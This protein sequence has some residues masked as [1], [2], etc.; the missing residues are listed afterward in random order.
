MSTK[1]SKLPASAKR[2]NPFVPY[3]R[4]RL[5][6]DAEEVS[7]RPCEPAELFEGLEISLGL[8]ASPL[9]ETPEEKH[10][11]K[12][13]GASMAAGKLIDWLFAHAFHGDEAAQGQIA[14]LARKLTQEFVFHAHKKS[15]GIL[16]RVKRWAEMPGWLSRSTEVQEEM[17]RLCRELNLG[18]HFPFPLSAK[19]AAK[20]KV[21]SIRSAHHE[22][23]DSLHGYI[24]GYRK[25]RKQFWQPLENEHQLYYV[26]PFVLRMANLPPL[27][28]STVMDWISVSRE[29]LKDA[30]NDNPATHPAFMKD[31]RYAN[32]GMPP[33]TS[34][35]AEIV[36]WKRLAEAWK[37][38]A[39][40]MGRLPEDAP[41][42]K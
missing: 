28:P 41:P 40:A 22:L 15:P 29:V 30:T 17:Q 2:E 27:S 8:I 34:K 39:K 10:R 16:P 3:F 23:V 35:R 13:I 11:E 26:N 6:G 20:G 7:P 19:E 21:P 4:F 5:P 12:I 1:K 14:D 32:L 25:G 38:R 31:G 37:L 42:R 33:P 9:G 18:D 24:E 36:L